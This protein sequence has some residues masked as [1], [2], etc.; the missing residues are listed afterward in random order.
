MYT[1]VIHSDR[2]ID[3]MI[4]VIYEF[5]LNYLLKKNEQVPITQSWIRCETKYNLTYGRGKKY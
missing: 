3:I 5:M 4:R 1:V 2:I